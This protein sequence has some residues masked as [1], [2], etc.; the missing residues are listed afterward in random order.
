LHAGGTCEF[1]VLFLYFVSPRATGR[2]FETQ[3]AINTNRY[4]PF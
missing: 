3:H 4:K 1:E 2:G